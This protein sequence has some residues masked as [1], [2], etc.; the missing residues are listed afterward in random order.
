MTRCGYSDRPSVTVATTRTSQFSLAVKSGA[1]VADDQE[2]IAGL[3]LS[4]GAGQI[5]AI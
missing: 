4:R 1:F 3:Q 5:D 2:Q